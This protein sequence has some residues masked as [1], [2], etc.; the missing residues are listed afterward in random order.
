MTVRVE[1]V[2]IGAGQAGLALSRGLTAAGRP[3]V[4]LERG[5]VGERWRSERWESLRLLTPNWLNR[6]PGAP[7]LPDPDGY[8][9]RLGSSSTSRRTRRGRRFTSG[10]TVLGV[11]R[12][13][14]GHLVVTDAGE[15]HARNVVIATGD[16]DVPRVPA[17]AADAPPFLHQ[18][19]ATAYRR[20]ARLPDGGVLVVGAGPS[21]QQIAA[22]LRRAGR[23]VVLAAGRHA[24]MPRTYR[25]RDVFAWLHA[26]GQ[27][28]DHVDHVPDLAAARRAPSFPVSG[29]HGGE[30]LGLEASRPSASSSPAASTASPAPTPCS[31]TR[32]S[33]TWPTPTAACC[34]SLA[35]FDAYISLAR[36]EAPAADPPPA[37]ELAAGRAAWTSAGGSPRSSGPPAT[38]ALSVAP[39]AR[40]RRERRAR[41]P[42]G[43]HGRPRSLR[44][45]IAVPAHPQ[46]ALPRRSGRR[47]GADRPRDR[48]QGAGARLERA[49]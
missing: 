6:L 38:A 49:A 36:V 22:E 21:G 24:R 19:H 25:G 27:L 33:A 4:V 34:R 40:P 7:A 32:S 1:T 18:L 26:T 20:P 5:R 42:A 41:A 35:L 11:R 30:S 10:T 8:L 2:I 39:R 12:S 44:A 29:A 9:D 3:H 15:W 46:V 37:V 13:R 45:G 16:C 23:D 17:I 48:R 43:R 31:A 14:R 28:D 47:R